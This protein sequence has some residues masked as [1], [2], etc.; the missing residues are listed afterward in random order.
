MRAVVQ[1]VKRASV[2]IVEGGK[3]VRRSGETGAGVLVL[4]GVENGDTEDDARWLANKIA[5][6]RIFE[7]SEGK[8]NVSLKD[9]GGGALLVSQFTL[10]GN[11][12]KGSRPSFNR[13]APPAVSVPLY[14]KFGELLESELGKKV[15]RGVFGAMMDVSLVNDGPVTI[16][17]DSQNKDI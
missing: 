3:T 14:E 2:D 9:S 16:I 7:D 13:S 11:V 6:L 8:M 17:M 10:Y 4:L 12:R 1:R 15:P 5:Q